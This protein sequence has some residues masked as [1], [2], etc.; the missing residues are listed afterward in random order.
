MNK[1]SLDIERLSAAYRDGVTTPEQVMGEVLERIAKAGDDHVWISRADDAVVLAQARALTQRVG[2]IAELPLYGLPFGVKDS[3]DVEGSPTTLACP[4]YAYT[5]ARSAAVVERLIEAG[6]IFIGKTNLDQFATGLVGVRSGYGTPRNPFDAAM[7]PGGSS[8]GSAVAVA[9]GQ[10]SFAVATDTAGSGRVPAAFNNIVGYKPTRGL[11][12]MDG[13]VP[14]CRSADCITLMGLTVEDTIKVARVMQGLDV[15]DAYSRRAPAGFM[16]NANVAAGPFKFGVPR[17]E[18]L[19]FF[20]D[21]EA[22][23]SSSAAIERAMRLGGE[24]VEID[25][26]PFLETGKLLYGPWVAERTADLGEFIA[27]HLDDVHPVVREIITGGERFSA[28]ELFRTQHRR[29]EL[30]RAIIPTWRAVDFML[31][32]TTGT[33]YSIDEVLAEPVKLNTNLGYYTTFAN[34]LDL[35]AIAIPN[36]F[37]DEGFSVRRDA[38]RARL[39]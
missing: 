5:P 34:L 10:V 26:A 25:F 18:Q 37:T 9:S 23:R 7:I 17:R 22:E 39:A 6:A 11:F 16:L 27:T 21:G 30:A 29:A 3:I 35:S 1:L 20:G 8:S 33:A 12:S 31:L 4:A 2:Q 32:P 38:D 13:L 14:A 36:G 24:M 15:T 19:E 28:A